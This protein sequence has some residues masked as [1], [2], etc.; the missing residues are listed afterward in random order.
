MTIIIADWYG[1]YRHVIG[2]ANSFSEAAAIWRTQEEDTNGEC[3]IVCY[4]VEPN[5]Q[6]K[7][8]NHLVKM[9]NPDIH[10]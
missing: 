2:K 3:D 1:N 7:I 10:Y 5:K 6:P 9:Y 4:L 8:I